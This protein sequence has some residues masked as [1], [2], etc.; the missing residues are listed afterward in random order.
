MIFMGILL[1]IVIMAAVA[2]MALRKD[3]TF[4]VRI[5][6]LAALGIMVLTIIICAFLVITGVEE[7]VD[8][9]VVIVTAVPDTP[10]KG[11]TGAGSMAIFMLFLIIFLGL[12]IVIVFRTLKEHRKGE[13]KKIIGGLDF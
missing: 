6:S 3:S 13:T 1:G 7:P 10:A 2:F 5:A 9:S 8:E 12:F 4:P 11:K